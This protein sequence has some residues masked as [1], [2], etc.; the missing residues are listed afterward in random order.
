M[1]LL[2]QHSLL[3]GTLLVRTD[4]N[5]THERALLLPQIALLGFSEEKCLT[6]AK[7]TEDT[8]DISMCQRGT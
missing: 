5:C 4:L 3:E 1:G 2:I 7:L 8:D 6:Q